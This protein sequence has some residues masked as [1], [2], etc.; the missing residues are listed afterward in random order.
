MKGKVSVSYWTV[1][2]SSLP[3]VAES[4]IRIKVVAP[5][6]VLVPVP[7]PDAV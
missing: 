4:K 3:M 5:T 1:L 2:V 6:V 7:D